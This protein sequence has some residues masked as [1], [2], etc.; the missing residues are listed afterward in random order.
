M[1]KY[2]MNHTSLHGIKYPVDVQLYKFER[3]IWILFVIFGFCCTITVTG[4]LNSKFQVSTKISKKNF[5]CFSQTKIS[6][7]KDRDTNIVIDDINYEVF[8]VPFPSVTLCP[9]SRMDWS[10]VEKI[11]NS[12][13]SDD[14]KELKDGFLN[15]FSNM[16]TLR[17]SHLHELKFN[18]SDEALKSLNS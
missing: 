3:I 13:I 14:D 7:F 4:R 10:E 1:I 15:F 11:A 6:I 12:L 8:R 18:A 5:K 17:L 2:F 9:S 16:S